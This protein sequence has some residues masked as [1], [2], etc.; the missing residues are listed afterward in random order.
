MK[1]F[2][3][4]LTCMIVLQ[5]FSQE[6][7]TIRGKV[8]DGETKEAMPFAS[9]AIYKSADSS[10]VTGN[11][12]NLEGHFKIETTPGQ[13]YLI[14]KILSYDDYVKDDFKLQKDINLGTL[15]VYPNSEQL[16]EFE[17][18]EEKSNMEFKLDKRVFNVEKDLTNQ[19]GT[20]SDILEN[21]PSVTLD[22][23]GNVALRGSQNV[24]IFINGKPSGLT[25]ISPEMALQ[26]IPAEMIEKVEVI[27]NPSARYEAA[28]E[29]GIINIVLKKNKKKGFNGSVQATAGWPELLGASTTLNYKTEKFNL[30]GTYSFRKDNRPGFG[31]ELQTYEG[32]DTSYQFR[33]KRDHFRG[34][35]G[36]NIRL[37]S[38]LFL[39]NQNTLT[40]TGMYAREDGENG[41]NRTYEDLD[42]NGNL[43]QTVNRIQDEYEPEN[44]VEASLNYRKTFDKE[45]RLFTVDLQWFINDEDEIADITQT[46]D[47]ENSTLRQRTFN[48]EDENNFLFQT[49]YIHPFGKDDN[50]K[51]ETGLRTTYRN[52]SNEFL[53]EEQGPNDEWSVLD[54]F[55]NQFLYDEFIQAGYFIYGAEWKKLSIQAG[56]RGEYTDVNSQLVASEI[57]N[58]QQYFNLFPSA[59]FSYKIDSV[60]T[61]QLSYSRRV[62]R[63]RFRHLLPFYSFTDPRDFYA[64]NPNLQPEFTDAFEF[65]YL[66]YFDKGSFLSS[67]YYRY[68][69]DVVERITTT[70]DQGYSTSFPVNLAIQNAI[71]IEMNLN[72]E[73]FKW[74][75]F[76]GSGNFYRA[77]TEGNYQ[78]QELNSDTY[79]WSL[80][81]NNSFNITDK[82]KSQLAFNYRAPII[83]TQ[84]T[85]EAVYFFNAGINMK[86]LKGKGTIAFNVRDV[87][88]S[89][90][91][92]SYTETQYLTKESEFQWR[93]RQFTLNFTYRF[94]NENKN[95]KSD[96]QGRDGGFD[97]MDE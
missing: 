61:L 73:L 27:T 21:I 10:L 25:G 23:E 20:A 75:Q 81:V 24:K 19:G 89:R 70:D 41:V 76:T 63:P 90:V 55:D 95:D 94:K 31:N 39:N 65:A 2:T 80:N 9:V 17:F 59:H 35:I 87:L 60:N 52:I 56:V 79:T 28:G 40:L 68:R 33:N 47:T 51:I 84:G 71:G 53:V 74:W 22:A 8:V 36:H 64:G 16:D 37:G 67:V 88:N 18:V 14:V 62:N 96:R 50:M 5:S 45:D 49:D 69:T 26:Q 83:R 34:G 86:I 3:L 46:N 78:G 15:V 77:I 91:F 7:L 29:V 58:P 54:S 82:I 93:A 12:T 57:S 72:Y 1:Y 11:A 44:N 66:R 92:R 13:Y 48:T 38:E 4:F 43:V 30:F 85:R 42:E 6:I 97:D 32:P